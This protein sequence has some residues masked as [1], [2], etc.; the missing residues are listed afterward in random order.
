[1]C[2]GITIVVRK[3][4]VAQNHIGLETLSRRDAV[5]RIGGDVQFVAGSFEHKFQR[6]DDIG[7]IFDQK[8]A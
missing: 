4:N 1:M 3:P 7:A 5:N 2:D 8:Y 6:G